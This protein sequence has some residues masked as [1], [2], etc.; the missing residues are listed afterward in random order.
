MTW[1][2]TTKQNDRCYVPLIAC[3]R[4]ISLAVHHT[5]TIHVDGLAG[6]FFGSF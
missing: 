4:P 1:R 6:H 2:L 3:H 5:A